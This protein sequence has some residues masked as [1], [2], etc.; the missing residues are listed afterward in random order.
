MSRRTISQLAHI[1]LATPRLEASRDF[2]VEVLGL[3][4][5]TRTDAGIFLRAWG[6]DLHHSLLLV[7][8]DAP[9]VRRIGWRAD[10]AED[11]ERVARDLDAD[12]LGEGWSDGDVGHGRSYQFRSPGGNPHEIFWDFTPFAVPDAMRS[13]FPNRL[14]KFA[15][16]GVGVRRIDHVTIGTDDVWRDAHWFRDNLDFRIMEYTVFEGPS[17]APFFAQVSSNEQAHNLGIAINPAGGPPATHHIAFWLDQEVDVLRAADIL[18]ETGASL[19][20]GPGKHGMGENTYLY[21]R[22]PGGFRIELFSGG[23]RNY[24]PDWEPVRWTPQQGSN[25]M[26]LNREAPES[27]ME[28]FPGGRASVAT[29]GGG[30]VNPFAVPSVS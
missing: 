22:E 4:E 29:Q 1:E 8:G 15:P 28:M 2:F 3:S 10:S 25:D 24:M 21:V 27:M 13:R 6:D 17:E 20:Y 5:V 11:M 12:G 7:E 18:L 9:E 26:Y 23:Y 16:R 19:E 30:A 14:Q